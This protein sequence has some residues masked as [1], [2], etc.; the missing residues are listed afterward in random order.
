MKVMEFENKYGKI[1]EELKKKGR[2]ALK[3]TEYKNLFEVLEAMNY[4]LAKDYNEYEE[5][6][7]NVG[8]KATIDDI[9]STYNYFYDYKCEDAF[10]KR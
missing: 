10:E 3:G 5:W 4:D 7:M 8:R 2:N 6:K 9:E 1:V